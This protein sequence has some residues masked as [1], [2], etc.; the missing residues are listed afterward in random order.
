MPLT[1]SSATVARYRDL[2]STDERARADRF[3]FPRDRDSYSLS[4]GALRLLLANYLKADAP[5]I[6]LASGPKGKPF[7]LD[8]EHLSFNKS[9]SKGMALYAFTHD[10]AVGV[11]VEG[12][13]E[14]PDFH[15]IAIRFFCPLEAQELA[16]AN[17]AAAAFFRCWTRKEAYIKAVGDGLSM[18]LDQFQVTLLREDPVRFVHIGNDERAASQWSLH[19]LD[20]AS[21]YIGALAYAGARRTLQVHGIVKPEDLLS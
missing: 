13:R 21:G 7:L 10:C 9:H 18:P 12:L 16:S 17:D 1:G 19:H 15:E 8:E 5:E 14:L 4:Q 11:D 20:P 2:L 3:I 6:R